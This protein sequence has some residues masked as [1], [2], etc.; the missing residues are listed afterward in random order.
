MGRGEER[1]DGKDERVRK[2]QTD[3]Q[4]ER[5]VALPIPMEKKKKKIPHAFSACDNCP[6]T[7]CLLNTEIN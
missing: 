5:G 4:A 3:R 7:L 2:R 6:Q 1:G